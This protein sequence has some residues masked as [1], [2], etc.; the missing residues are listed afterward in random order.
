MIIFLIF[1]ELLI[2]HYSENVDV[3]TSVVLK[4]FDNVPILYNFLRISNF[5]YKYNRF[6]KKKIKSGT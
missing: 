1:N 4:L 6:E 5:K 2:K 3:F